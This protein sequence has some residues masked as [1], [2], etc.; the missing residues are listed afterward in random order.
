MKFDEF[1]SEL[2]KEISIPKRFKTLKQEKEFEAHYSSGIVI[3]T[4]RTRYKRPIGKSEFEKVWNAFKK[5]LDPYRPILY[6]RDTYHASYILAIIKYFLKQ[7]KA[8]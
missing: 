3:V 8:E 5:N 7:K 2:V 1:W 4:P 6:Q